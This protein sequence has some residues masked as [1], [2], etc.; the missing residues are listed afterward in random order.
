MPSTPTSV[1]GGRD[2]EPRRRRPQIFKSQVRQPSR[3]DPGL[4]GAGSA[5]HQGI[6]RGELESRRTHPLPDPRNRPARLGDYRPR[7]RHGAAP[8]RRHGRRR[9][10][11][12]DRGIH[13]HAARR[14]GPGGHRLAVAG[15]VRIRQHPRSG[16]RGGHRLRLRLD[17]R[18]PALPPQD[19]ERRDSRHA[20]E[21]TAR[22]CPT[23]LPPAAPRAACRGRRTEAICP[24]TACCR[25]WCWGVSRGAR[26]PGKYRRKAA[27][28]FTD[29]VRSADKAAARSNR[30]G[31]SSWRPRRKRPA[32]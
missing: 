32:R 27:V 6:G 31:I 8:L 20:G 23:C 1:N 22:R 7:H 30:R 29:A 4:R 12:A 15:E 16:R 21:S 3:R 18:R 28:L 9:G 11:R 25:P 17:Q 19:R 5:R 13:R 24:A 10:G 26:Q 14:L 2:H